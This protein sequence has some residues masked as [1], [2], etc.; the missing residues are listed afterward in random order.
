MNGYLNFSWHSPSPDS[1]L[2]LTPRGSAKGDVV[3]EVSK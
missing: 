1:H 2:P 3:V